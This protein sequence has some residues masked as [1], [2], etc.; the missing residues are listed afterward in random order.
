MSEKPILF[1]GEM[2]RAIRE[3]R[4]TQTRRPV[5]LYKGNHSGPNTKQLED[6]TW[7]Q[8]GCAGI[9]VPFPPCPFGPVGTRL[10]VRETFCYCDRLYRGYELD[11]PCT[12]GYR[13][14]LSARTVQESGVAALIP[15]DVYAWNWEHESVRWL[16]SIHMPRWASRIT[17][18]VQRV[19]V[20]R[21]LDISEKDAQLEG[22]EHTIVGP[23]QDGLKYR[24]YKQGFSKLWNSIYAAKGYG[25][26]ANPWVW[27]CEFEVVEYGKI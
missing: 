21:V 8:Y 17:L 18:E 11:D 10:W 16:P 15:V 1:N 13:A 2:V 26:N 24:V 19:W 22:V 5:K 23:C 27:A 4:K 20:E 12:V 3:G 7:E 6:G 9:W 25:W 14:D